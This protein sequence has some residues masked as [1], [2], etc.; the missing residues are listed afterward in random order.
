MDK[1][2]R[3]VLA[4]K[5]I[6]ESIEELTKESNANNG[7]I[8]SINKQIDELTK[9]L[10]NNTSQEK[11]ALN[12]LKIA[13]NEVEE[14]LINKIKTIQLTPGP[15]GD[16]G[17]DGKDGKDGVG[18]DGKDG[19]DGKD[20]LPGK[21]GAT[22][23]PGKNGRDGKDGVDGI[24]IVNVRIDSKGHLIIKFSEG[25]ERDVGKVVGEN[26]LSVTGK[27][28]DDGVSV[29]N[30][31]IKDH[32]LWITLSDGTEIN[33]GYIG[34]TGPGEE[35]D[36]IFTNSPAYNITDENITDWNNKA[37]T[38]DIPTKVSELDNDSGYITGYTETDPTVP[39]YVKQITENDITS[40]NNKS[41][42]SGS[43][44]DLTDK[45]TIPDELADLQDDTT[46]RLVTDTEKS[47][48]NNKSDFSGSY[49]DLTDKPSIPTKTSD[50]TNDSGFIDTT[51]HDSTKVDVVSGKGLST[52]D[53][54]DAY[55]DDVVANTTARHSHSNKTV[56]DGISSN[57]I[58]NWNNKSDF[59]G[60]YND[61]TDKPTIPDELSDLADDSTHR[62]VTDTEKTTWNNKQ[63][64][65]SD[66]S[67]IRSGAS[68]G[69]TA[70]Q[71]ND[72]V[73]DLVNDANYITNFYIPITTSNTTTTTW[74]E[75]WE[76][77][78]SNTIISA[79]IDYLESSTTV[80][81]TVPLYSIIGTS[82]GGTMLFT[83]VMGTS[84]LTYMVTG[85]GSNACT[86]TVQ[87]RNFELLSNKTQD[88]ITN[89]SSTTL[90]PSAN[91][92]YKDFQRKP[93]VVWE[94]TTPANYLTGIQADLSASPAWQLT[95]LDLTPYKRIKI[96]SCAGQK[97]SGIGVDASTTPAMILEMSLDSRNAISAYGGNYVGS[98]ISQKPNDANR[99]ATLTCAVSADKTSFVVLR[100]TNLYGTGATSNNDVNANVFMIEGYYD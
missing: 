68:A 70:L 46:H 93:V 23:S 24:S 36:P 38:S 2:I 52:N 88:I 15:K 40:W 87:T 60:S 55:K 97:T 34:G 71:P 41:E 3:I 54:T 59:S 39:S 6:K 17:K 7:H 19:R 98:I 13:L 45:P 44:N 51:Y 16:P 96:Y 84:T 79:R 20:G 5:K 22:G 10:A 43:Y 76:A 57:D 33:A 25:T 32:Y 50:L 95:N 80:P 21:T 74:E 69:A 75:I 8:D 37:E 4:I 85:T 14:N 83:F 67:T 26:G 35:I 12:E 91:A 66:L 31:E 58:T 86:V 1:D 27:A 28:G 81:V 62:L 82:S 92:V 77:Y 89:S 29:T 78:T 30:A 48:W 9:E 18:K 100:Q 99:L 47:T 94:E 73:S 49:T 72:N 63:D 11:N 65:I 56:L 90:Y 42:F 61:L 64:A 53:F